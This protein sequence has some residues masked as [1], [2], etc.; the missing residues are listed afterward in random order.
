M[1]IAEFQSRA[2]GTDS[3][4]QPLIALLGLAGEIGSLYAVYKKRL[5]DKPAHEQFRMELAEELGD[6]LWYIAAL[7]TLHKI[8]LNTVATSNLEKTQAFFGPPES[9]FFDLEFPQ[10]E[11]L[12]DH[13]TVEFGLD[14]EGRSQMVFNGKPLG[15]SLS[16]NSHMEDKYRFHDAFHLAFMTHLH[17][18]PVMRR[19]L[20]RKRKSVQNIDENEDG[21]RAAIVEEA[22]AA[23]IFTNAEEA[24][25]FPTVESIPMKLVTLLKKMTSKF[26]V[27]QCST[28]A[29]RHAIYDGCRAFQTLAK[30]SGGVVE[31]DLQSSILTVE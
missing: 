23:I 1:D 5:R 7:A 6:V 18:S 21:A 14:N 29:W 10:Q 25:F 22:V 2:A 8:D 24:N 16:D 9:P 19:L 17:W 20:K 26:E 28:S 11:R 4:K 27:S 30:N 15:D 3:T 31:I 12:P 13:M